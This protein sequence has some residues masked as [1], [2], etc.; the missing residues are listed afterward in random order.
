MRKIVV[1]LAFSLFGATGSLAD[2]PDPFFSLEQAKPYRER[3][4]NCTASVAKQNLSGPR[5][6]PVVADLAF[7]R[8][9]AQETALRNVLKRRL[10]AVSADRIVG[11]LRGFDRSLL[12]RIIDKLRADQ[13]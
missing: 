1:L 7:E 5:S 10:G 13:P 4:Q 11:D 6:A 9:K 2:E 3:W 8:C 12:I